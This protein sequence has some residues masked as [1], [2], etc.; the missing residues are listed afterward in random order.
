MDISEDHTKNSWMVSRK[1]SKPPWNCV[2]YVACYQYISRTEGISRLKSVTTFLCIE[3]EKDITCIWDKQ[4]AR[5]SHQGI[6]LGRGYITLR[7]AD[8]CGVLLWMD[9]AGRTT[10][11]GN[12]LSC[13]IFCLRQYFILTC[14]GD[15]RLGG[16]NFSSEAYYWQQ[17]P[18]LVLCTLFA[19][20]L[21][22]AIS[23]HASQWIISR[24]LSL[25]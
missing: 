10:S 1:V 12:V 11:F 25:L 13:R 8:F 7:N 6:T 5:A 23:C 9:S 18:R 24:W 4:I 22:L 3:K 14:L 16:S 21:F 20:L 17:W 2:F 19:V 15:G